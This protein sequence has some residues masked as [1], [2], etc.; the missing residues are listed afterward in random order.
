MEDT[1]PYLLRGSAGKTI[2]YNGRAVFVVPTNIFADDAEEKRYSKEHN[3]AFNN[4]VDKYDHEGFEAFHE[5]WKHTEATRVV[6]YFIERAEMYQVGEVATVIPLSEDD[7]Q[8]IE[9]ILKAAEP[10]KKIEFWEA[11]ETE[12]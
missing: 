3:T 1:K 7:R 4:M 12:D 6:G 11:P 9:K 5:R 2:D 10:D 8:G